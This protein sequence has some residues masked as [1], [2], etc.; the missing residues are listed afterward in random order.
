MDRQQ[1]IIL[2][3]LIRRAVREI[4]PSRRVDFKDELIVAMY[5]WTVAHD[6]PLCW[7]CDRDH[8]HRP[9]CP[10]RLPSVSQ[11]CRRVKTE[12]FQR[13]LQHL[14]DALTDQR[15]LS[16]V[17]FLDGK[18]LAVG[19]YSR[20]LEAKTGYGTGRLDKG[21]KLHAMVTADR[22]IVAWSVLPLNVHEMAVARV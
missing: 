9:F 4:G 17:N 21:Y 10:R 6:R 12:R 15:A 14:H 7:A 5:R 22:R 1:W 13:Y 18:P 8:Y 3:G 11:F 19:P 2:R 16:A 20:D